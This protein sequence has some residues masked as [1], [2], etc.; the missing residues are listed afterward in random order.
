[1]DRAIHEFGEFCVDVS[2]RI[3]LRGNVSVPL[4]PKVFDTLLH[5]VENHGKIVEKEELMRAIWPERSSLCNTRSN[6]PRSPRGRP[7]RRS[8]SVTLDGV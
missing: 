7:N 4:T 2:K 6:L 8:S 1:M 5:L 3:L